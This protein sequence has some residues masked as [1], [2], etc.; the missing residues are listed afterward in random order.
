MITLDG[1]IEVPRLALRDGDF[2][3]VVSNDNKLDIRAVDI[4]RRRP[5]SVLVSGGLR[6][7]DR[8][9]TS[10]MPSAVQGMELRVSPHVKTLG[11]AGLGD[12][13]TR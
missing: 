13:V 8:V 1:L 3:Y 5:E 7:G 11:D 6:E 9:I 12:E 2:V 4:A 10:A